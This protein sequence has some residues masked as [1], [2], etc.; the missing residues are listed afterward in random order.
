MNIRRRNERAL[1]HPAVTKKYCSSV[2]LLQRAQ[3]CFQMP[4][5]FKER[6]GLLRVYMRR[7]DCSVTDFS[8]YSSGI[9]VTGREVFHMTVP[10]E[11]QSTSSLMKKLALYYYWLFLVCIEKMLFQIF[12]GCGGV[13][14]LGFQMLIQGAVLFRLK[15]DHYIKCLRFN[16]EEGKGKCAS[17]TRGTL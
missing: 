14:G 13:G 17:V 11:L 7:Q 6:A 2:K 5:H 8:V 4:H 1:Y 15:C 10:T 12:D 3:P 16:Q 9:S